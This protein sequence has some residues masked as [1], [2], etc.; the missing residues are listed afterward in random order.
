MC[1]VSILILSPG[2]A[3]KRETPNDD[4]EQ[5]TSVAVDHSN[6]TEGDAQA[7]ARIQSLTFTDVHGEHHDPFEDQNTKGFV[8]VFVATDCPIA[9]YYQ[10][11]LTEMTTNYASD[12]VPFYL[13]YSDP[14][15]KTEEAIKHADEFKTKAPIVLDT[16]Q[17][18]AKLVGAKVTP[19][20]FVIDRKGNTTYGG[21]ID[22]LYADYGKRRAQPTTNDLKDAIELLLRGEKGEV[23]TKAI[24]CYI[25][26][27]KTAKKTDRPDEPTE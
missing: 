15:V 12:S 13:V 25:P 7:I 11:K 10:P 2:C 24:G 19:E 1:L 3:A 22:D 23:R 18:I 8:L 26:Y 6:D 20:A 17:S 14:D 4:S 16:E 27:L 21:R 9:N 5:D